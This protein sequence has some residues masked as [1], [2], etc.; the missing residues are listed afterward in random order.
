MILI[1]DMYPVSVVER[2]ITQYALSHLTLKAGI[3]VREFR[4]ACCPN[5]WV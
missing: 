1:S 4:S 2:T 5:F 3:N